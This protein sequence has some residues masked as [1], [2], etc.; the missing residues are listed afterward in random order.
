MKKQPCVLA[1]FHTPDW[2]IGQLFEQKATFWSAPIAAFQ[3][4]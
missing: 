3:I 2:Q 1:D 4:V